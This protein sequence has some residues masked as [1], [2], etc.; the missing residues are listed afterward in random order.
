MAWAFRGA[1]QER[2][3]GLA[4]VSLRDWSLDPG[5][6]LGR[7][8]LLGLLLQPGLRDPHRYFREPY[9]SPSVDR[10]IRRGFHLCSVHRAGLFAST[11]IPTV[12]PKRRIYYIVTILEFGPNPRDDT[13]VTGVCELVTSDVSALGRKSISLLFIYMLRGD[14]GD[15]LTPLSPRLSPRRMGSGEGARLS[16]GDK[17]GLHYL[18]RPARHSPPPS[19]SAS[20]GFVQSLPSRN[21]NEHTG[22]AKLAA[23]QM[24]IVSA[25]LSVAAELAK[26]EIVAL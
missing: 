15:K 9:Q 26:W 1:S 2:F 4:R 19:A 7:S 24:R 8:G 10:R 20:P 21:T 13:E 11:P 3:S 12:G 22:L 25:F 23:R 16:S 17:L 5:G 18:P 14:R 6:G